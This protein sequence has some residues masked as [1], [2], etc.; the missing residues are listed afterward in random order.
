MSLIETKAC[1]GKG[2]TPPRRNTLSAAKRDQIVA[3]LKATPNVTQVAKQLSENKGTV[4]RIAKAE[5]IKIATKPAYYRR[6]KP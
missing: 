4:W 3:A 1:S 2:C 5:G 6:E